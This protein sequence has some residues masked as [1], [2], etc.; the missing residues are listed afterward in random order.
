MNTKNKKINYIYINSINISI[1]IILIFSTYLVINSTSWLNSWIF[2]EINIITFIPLIINKSKINKSTNRIIKYFIIQS[3][4]SS[5]LFLSFIIINFF[6]INELFKINYLIKIIISIALLIKIGAAPFHWWIPHIIIK[7]NW[8]NCFLLLTWQ[9]LAP[10]IIL[11]QI[12]KNILINLCALIS[13]IFGAILGINQTSIKIL[14]TYSSINH[15]GWII[16]NRLINKFL[17]ILYLF[18]YS[19]INFI[20]CFILNFINII[21]INQLFKNFNKNSFNK[22]FLIIILLSLGGL[23]PFLGFLPKIISLI[24][25]LKNLI[26]LESIIIILTTLIVLKFYINLII[27]IININITKIKFSN[28]KYYINEL[29]YSLIINII[30][31]F[32]VISMI[33]FLN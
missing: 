17:I 9:K 21:Y 31:R 1:L 28:S 19:L 32:I 16:I 23:P 11:I 30:I 2:L 24:I 29:Y 22:L 27:P 13:I 8:K 33:N 10:L 5:F 4:S 6:I 25:T 12:N 26:F 18:I 3:F 15:I 7:L 20:I 14:L